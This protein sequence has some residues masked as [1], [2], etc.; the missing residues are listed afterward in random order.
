MSAVYPPLTE[1]MKQLIAELRDI[2]S[3]PVVEAAYNDAI[4]N[5]TPLIEPTGE[6]NPWI[7]QTIDYFVEYF[8][9]WFTFLPQPNGGLGKI[10]P[11]TYFY[12]NNETA[13]FFL[14]QLKSR[15][16]NAPYTT[17]IFNWTVKFILARGEFMDSPESKQYIKEWEAA[18][19]TQIQDFIIPKG[20]Y[21]SFNQFFTRELNPEVNARPIAAYDDDSILVAPADS[22]INFIESDLTLTTDLR[23]KT[24]EINVFELLN[25]SQYAQH[26]VG[27]TAVSCVLMPNNYHRFHSPVAGNIVE[28]MDV[29]GIYNGITDGEHW[30]NHFNVGESTTNFSI[31]EDFH[32][33]YYIIETKK[34]G[35]VALIPVGLNTISSISAS[36]VNNQSTMVPPDA[37][38]VAVKKGD[39]LGHFA[40]GGSLNILLFQSGVFNAI[41]VLMGQRLGS[42][43]SVSN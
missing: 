35:Y 13:F 26:F 21:Q 36:L 38:P 39:E 6:R 27:G 37:C 19:A 30:F 10:V 40:Y 24:R 2:V 9:Q 4:A 16:K 11:F 42:L 20:G 8:E 15:R 14:N 12:R 41:S 5:V 17:E 32:R 31:F 34:Y 25:K 43:S 18:P 28:S 1:K 29:P 7:G 33:A 23:V 3:N 22:E